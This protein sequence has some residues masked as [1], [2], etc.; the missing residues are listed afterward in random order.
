MSL[1][2]DTVLSYLPPKRK[3]TP[4][5]WIS[6]DAVCCH[7]NGTSADHRQRGGVIFNGDAVSYSCFNCGFTA[8]WQPSRLLSS[9]FKKLLRWLNVPDDTISK[10]AIEALRFKEIESY[11]GTQNP[12][13]TFIDKELP[14]GAKPIKE[15]LDDP[16]SELIPV[17]EYIQSRGLY[18]DDYNWHW[19][20]ELGFKNRLIIPFTYKNK[21][22]GYT[23]RMVR[24]GKPKYISDQQPGYVFNLDAQTYDKDFVI[25]CEGPLDA[26]SIGGVALTG[27]EIKSGQQ[28]LINQLQKEVIVVPDRDAAGQKIVEQAIEAGWSVSF[29]DWET[30]IKDLNEAVTRYGRLYTLWSVITGNYSMPLKIRLHSKMWF[31]EED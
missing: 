12:L 17:L 9:K 15:L 27:S 22:V 3:V 5:Q 28:A 18:L 23:A 31:K 13:P 14:L 29:P 21:I 25:V 30:G 8:S 26:I 6:F 11:T 7:H 4:S 16:P 19:T 24:D 2:T 10:C 20:D 1:I